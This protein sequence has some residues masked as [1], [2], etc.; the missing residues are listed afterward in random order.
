MVQV[1]VIW[2]L[3]LIVYLALWLSRIAHLRRDSV[4]V[5]VSSSSCSSLVSLL[6]TCART[7]SYT[8]IFFLFDCLGWIGKPNDVTLW[9]ASLQL[10]LLLLAHYVKVLHSCRTS[11]LAHWSPPWSNLTG[12]TIHG[13]SRGVMPI[14]LRYLRRQHHTTLLPCYTITVDSGRWSDHPPCLVGSILLVYALTYSPWAPLVIMLTLF[15]WPVPL[16]ESCLCCLSRMRSLKTATHFRTKCKAG[17]FIGE[18][19]SLLSIG[20]IIK[21]HVVMWLALIVASTCILAWLAAWIY[22]YGLANLMP[23]SSLF[24]VFNPNLMRSIIPKESTIVGV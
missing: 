14:H 16:L 12:I 17:Q 13:R 24:C 1:L 10:V 19:S 20:I 6:C 7:R 4:D 8:N 18:A 3:P 21:G 22:A 5:G 9:I 15:C 23:A 2:V 11:L